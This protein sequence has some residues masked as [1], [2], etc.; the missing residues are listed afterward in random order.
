[1]N[2]DAGEFRLGMR[3]LAAGVTII[4]S[5]HEGECMGMTATAVCSLTASPPRLLACVNLQGSTYRLICG[6]RRLAV[7]VLGSSHESVA[8]DFSRPGK[9]S[10]DLFD[11]GIW[12]L[13][14]GSPV[15]KG[16]LAAFRCS[17]AHMLLME[18]HAIVI[19]EVE[20]VALGPS[21]PPLLYADGHYGELSPSL[22]LSVTS[23]SP[24]RRTA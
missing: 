10:P 11:A 17:V 4:T 19:G 16:A 13:A 1:M 22:P 15:L 6:S 21:Q 2:C 18:T 9:R 12:D 3:R 5:E 8:R 23:N 14:A 24:F 7:N 20:S